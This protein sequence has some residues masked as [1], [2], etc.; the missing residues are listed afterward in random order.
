MRVRRGT[1]LALWTAAAVLFGALAAAPISF[2]AESTLPGLKTAHAKGDD[3]GGGGGGGGGGGSD[4]DHGNAGGNGGGKGGG[5]SNAGANGNGKALGLNKK[6]REEKKTAT[7]KAKA[8]NTL[9]AL[10]AAHASPNALSHAAPTSRVGKIAA[11]LEAIEASASAE[12]DLSDARDA[13]AA[14]QA[15]VTDAQAALDSAT[16]DEE[17]AAAQSALD[18]ANAALD[19]AE[20]DLE[21]AETAAASAADAEHAAIEAASN[22]ETVTAEMVD[23]V[24]DLLGI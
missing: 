3:H 1:R 13:V 20:A 14:A 8:K 5:Q 19:A 10:N 15:A 6:T 22:K 12:V 16:T 23:A 7:G 2:T 4:R 21:A 9:G 24:R 17:R 18:T 11:Y